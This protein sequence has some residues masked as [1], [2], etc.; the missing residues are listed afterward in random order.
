V[1]LSHAVL[2]EVFPDSDLT[3]EANLLV[4]PNMDAAYFTYNVVRTVSGHGVAIGAILLGAARPVHILTP[5]ATVRR[6]V[7]MSAL[8]VVDAG[9]P[10]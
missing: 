10:G 4:M 8:A 5:A 9:S 2:D 6:I 7:N 1:A 3:R